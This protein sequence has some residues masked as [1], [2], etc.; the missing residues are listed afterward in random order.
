M[1]NVLDA[2]DSIANASVEAMGKLPEVPDDVTWAWRILESID[3]VNDRMNQSLDPVLKKLEIMSYG[4]SIVWPEVSCDTEKRL[5][6]ATESALNWRRRVAAGVDRL[7]NEA[8]SMI[9]VCEIQKLYREDLDMRNLI[10]HGLLG[11][12]CSTKADKDDMLLI[13][14][15][16]EVAAVVA[17]FKPGVLSQRA[18]SGLVNV[19]LD[20]DF[21]SAL[22]EKEA[23]EDAFSSALNLSNLVSEASHIESS[24]RAALNGLPTTK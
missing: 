17:S 8:V 10:D 16:G 20:R 7:R 11:I 4:T 1:S 18:T 15:S 22:D 5:R 21:L 24:M 12:V 19:N 3:G 13:F 9:I 2:I 6:E 23:K 14:D